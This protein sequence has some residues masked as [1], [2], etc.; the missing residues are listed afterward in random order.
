MPDSILNSQWFYT[1]YGKD[2]GPVSWSIIE[3]M[4]QE[5]RLSPQDVVMQEG[6]AIHMRIEDV[7]RI[8]SSPRSVTPPQGMPSVE[9]GESPATPEPPPVVVAAP[10]LLEAPVAS[11]PAPWPDLS[12]DSDVEADSGG[13]GLEAVPESPP[14][15]PEAFLPRHAKKSKSVKTRTSQANEEASEAE[16][17]ARRPRVTSGH[18]AESVCDPQQ[19]MFALEASFLWA[20][21]SAV[22]LLIGCRLGTGIR[23]L[24]MFIVFCLIM[25]L[26]TAIASTVG[27]MQSWARERQ[28][29]VSK[30]EG[31]KFARQRAA[32]MVIFPLMAVLSAGALIA[33]AT[34]VIEVVSHSTWFGPM[35]GSLLFLPAFFLVAGTV[36]GA[37]GASLIPVVMGIED[38]GPSEALKICQERSRNSYLQ[39]LLDCLAI[40][41]RITPQLLLTAI[42]TA[43]GISGAIKL[44]LNIESLL[45]F[46]LD[47]STLIAVMSYLIALAGWLAF[48]FALIAVNLADNYLGAGSE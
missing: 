2:Y 11:T 39:W 37:I 47:F 27:V 44:T 20:I 24:S 3:S 5:N 46:N 26:Y 42:I 38:C 34:S 21:S 29:S 18:A 1:S 31:W 4:L 16:P 43:A 35:L 8:L 45:E 13:Y 10:V 41:S 17:A 33:V 32:P 12:G 23:S 40:F 28:R 9:T 19:L 14:L 48:A 6:S 30:S 25:V 22:I 36:L 7:V 15:D